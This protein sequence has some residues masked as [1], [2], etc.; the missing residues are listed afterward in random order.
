MFWIQGHLTILDGLFV[1]NEAE[2]RGGVFLVK[3]GDVVV[4]NGIFEGNRAED[5][6]VGFTTEDSTLHV[7]GGTFSRNIAGN[8]G[9]VFFV[10]EDTTFAVSFEVDEGQI[11]GEERFVGDGWSLTLN[12]G[13]VVLPSTVC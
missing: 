5:G 4:Q 11:I 3:I 9:G 2:G 8:G 6:A 12:V 13:G 1:G 10:D 7:N